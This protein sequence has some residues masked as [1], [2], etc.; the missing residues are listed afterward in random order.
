MEGRVDAISPTRIPKTKMPQHTFR[1]V[2]ISQT[3]TCFIIQRIHLIGFLVTAFSSR[4]IFLNLIVKMSEKQ[5]DFTIIRIKF[6][7]LNME[8]K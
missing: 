5:K 6:R 3:G 4:R 8:E 1:N 2:N 7:R